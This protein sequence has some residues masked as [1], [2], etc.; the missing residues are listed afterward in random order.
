M[1]KAVRNPALRAG[2]RARKPVRRAAGSAAGDS[3][4][5]SGLPEL[6]PS[7]HDSQERLCQPVHDL[8]PLF[9]P[10]VLPPPPSAGCVAV[11]L[12]FPRVGDVVGE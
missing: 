2:G 7:H 4:A 10:P 3:V 9:G 1:P 8:S 12:A 5:S 6:T 11:P